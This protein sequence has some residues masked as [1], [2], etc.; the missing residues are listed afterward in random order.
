MDDILIKLV[1]IQ[2]ALRACYEYFSEKTVSVPILAT[3]LLEVRN[4]TDKYCLYPFQ[5]SMG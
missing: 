4:C 2:F 5:A 3:G 1:Y